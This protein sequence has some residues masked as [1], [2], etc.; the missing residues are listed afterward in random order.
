MLDQVGIPDAERRL[1]AVS[2]RVLGRH[3]PAG[4]DRHGA[5]LQPELLIADEPTT[6]LDVT[7]QAQILDLLARRCSG[8]RHGHVFVTHDLGVIAEIA[9]EVVVMY[10]GQKVEHATAG[11]L[12]VR[13]RHPYTE[14]LLSSMPQSTPIGSPLPVI[15]GVVP[16]P[17]DFPSGCRFRDRCRHAV[18]LRH[19]RG[20]AAPHPCGG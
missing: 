18:G 14:A 11:H 19:H 8:S 16:R 2:A 7:I 9:D 12:F 4:D 13:P 15:P 6:A 10:V 3:A 5:V 20:R 17:E 1:G